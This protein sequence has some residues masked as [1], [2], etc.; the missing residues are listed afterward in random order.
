VIFLLAACF[1]LAPG[2][3]PAAAADEAKAVDG[4]EAYL[5]R[6]RYEPIPFFRSEDNK[7]LV[8]AELGGKRHRFLV[9][10]GWGFTTLSPKSAAGLKT[11]REMGGVMEDSALG[12]LTNTSLVV[13][14][15]LV[16]GRAQFLNQPAQVGRL[17][18]DY[19]RFPFVGILGF[20]FL[21]RNFCLI[22]CGGNRLY[23]RGGEPSEAEKK[24]MAETLRRSGFTEIPMRYDYCM[25]VEV[26]INGEPV[27]LLVDTGASFSMVD[28]AVQKRL[29]LP[30]AKQDQPAT[31]TRINGEVN[32]LIVGVGSVGARTLR[33]VKLDT[34]Q[35]G[36]RVAK[37]V[38]FGTANLTPR[39]RT[40]AG[41]AAA[42]VQGLLGIE[43]LT[44]HGAVID[45]AGS[46][47]WL[48]PEPAKER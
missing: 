10:S 29:S 34:L 7:L 40:G 1:Y 28:D 3:P 18:G 2:G 45:L 8:N 22:D 5:K 20:D 39:S 14:E 23:V 15:K 47:L 11:L 44:R 25:M 9:D 35:I 33:V 32:G 41:S 48:R 36:D 26:K 13:M 17:T 12:R 6:L 16:L 43:M 42:E 27:P 37:H 30:T 31:G 19:V 24:A 38:H 46:T 21:V 4:L